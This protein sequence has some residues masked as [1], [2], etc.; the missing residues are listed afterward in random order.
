V[1]PLTYWLELVRRS[2]LGKSMSTTLAGY[3]NLELISIMAVT[4][5]V[6]AL[7]S[8]YIYRSIEYIARKHGKI[9]QIT[10]Y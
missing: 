5:L 7:F 10:N 9:D 6:L 8:H 2:I 4:T 1:L 3:S